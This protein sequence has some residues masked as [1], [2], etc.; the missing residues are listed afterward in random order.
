MSGPFLR[1]APSPN[2]YL[3]LGHGFSALFTWRAATHLGGTAL[4]RIEDIDTVRCKPEYDAAIREDLAW[5]G[6]D[7]PQPVLRQS[8]RFALYRAAA[9]RLGDLL[10]A[11]N[12]SRA[13]IAARATRTDPDGAPLYDGHCRHHPPP[14]GSQLQWRIKMDEAIARAG[15]LG[16]A[17]LAV[18]GINIGET[19]ETRLAN[20]ALWGDAVIVRKDTPTSY[21]LSVV[22]DDAAQGIT[23]VTRG[24]DLHAA[25]DLHA[26]LQKLLRLPAPIYAHHG[27]VCD[28][29]DLKLSK[30]KRSVSLRSLREA[31][32]LSQDIRGQ[33]GF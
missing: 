25:T 27:L 6:L 12:C 3:H 10:Y 26:L 18:D 24:M 29:A 19:L 21:H 1:F 5:L 9:A 31:G 17:E 32:W 11:C 13:E 2:G 15:P 20:P 7:W 14:A 23:H 30:S 4:L 22:V 16:I 28:D 33:L 8:E